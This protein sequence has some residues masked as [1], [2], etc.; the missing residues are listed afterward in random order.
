VQEKAIVSLREINFFPKNWI[1]GEDLNAAVRLCDVAACMVNRDS[2]QRPKGTEKINN[3]IRCPFALLFS[4]PL[5]LCGK[6]HSLLV[7]SPEKHSII[8]P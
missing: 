6:T 4:V 7:R 8:L 3:S 1:A 2:P 5:C